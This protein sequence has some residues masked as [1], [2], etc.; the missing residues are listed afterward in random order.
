MNKEINTFDIDGVIYGPGIYP[1]PDDIIITGRSYEE[2]P[3]T[4]RMLHARG[5]RNQVFFN[6]LEY[7]DKTRESSG[8]HK[9][10]TIDWLNRSG[11]KVVNHIEDDEIQ[12]EAIKAYFRNNMLPGCP[13]IV[14]VVSDIVPKENFRH[15]D[16]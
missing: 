2:E 8:L 7:E 4:M 5:I 6:T 15:V 16:F 10:R 3:E 13:V 11:Y 9:A 12:I 1:G 14:H